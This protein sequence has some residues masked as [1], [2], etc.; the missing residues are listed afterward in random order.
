VPDGEY[1]K[2]VDTYWNYI[3]MGIEFHY[4]NGASSGIFGS[5]DDRGKAVFKAA[6]PDHILRSIAVYGAQA[7]VSEFYFGFS[8]NPKTFQ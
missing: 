8:P 7:G 2:Q 5:G 3:C 6:Y 4:T 1:I